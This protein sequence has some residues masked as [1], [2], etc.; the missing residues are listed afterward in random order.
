MADVNTSKF[1]PQFD[2]RESSKIIVTSSLQKKEVLTRLS[3]FSSRL[4][5][6]SQFAEI[7]ETIAW[8]LMSNAIFNAPIHKDSGEKK[9]SALPRDQVI[10]LA[11]DEYVDVEFGLQD[12]DLVLSV[13]DQFG[14]LQRTAVV[15]N[16]MRCQQKGHDQVKTSPGG[17]GMGLF[18]VLNMASQLDLYV[19]PNLSTTAVRLFNISKRQ[20]GYEE[21]GIALNLFFKE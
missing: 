2:I 17:A 10:E 19:I 12:D 3:R 16:L 21:Y 20:K 9:Y 14:L 11:R 1:S 8:E 13:Q 7:V 18:M 6:F 15:N 4:S 5:G